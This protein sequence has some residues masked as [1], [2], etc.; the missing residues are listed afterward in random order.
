MFNFLSIL[1][2]GAHL[3]G[4]P[5]L[6]T[7]ARLVLCQG[8]KSQTIQIFVLRCIELLIM[9]IPDICHGRHGHT[10]VNFFWP[11]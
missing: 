4:V 3:L 10:R 2:A 7:S 11:V 6:S 1:S 5:T 9:Y 8:N